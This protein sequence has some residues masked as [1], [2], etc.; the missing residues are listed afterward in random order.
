MFVPRMLSGLLIAL[1]VSAL[2]CSSAM[3]VAPTI[4][5]LSIANLSETE[6]V[7]D[8]L[9]RLTDSQG[10]PAD[11]ITLPRGVQ[12]LTILP[13]L[14]VVP[15]NEPIVGQVSVK[16]SIDLGKASSAT[17]IQLA[18][19]KEREIA[20]KLALLLESQTDVTVQFASGN[21]LETETGLI[22]GTGN[23]TAS[24]TA[25]AESNAPASVALR[26]S[27]DGSTIHIPR[28]QIVTISLAVSDE[29]RTIWICKSGATYLRFWQAIPSPWQLYYRLAV[30]TTE[31]RR[32][33]IVTQVVPFAI[34]NNPTTIPLDD[35]TVEVIPA[36]QN[37]G[38]QVSS[39]SMKPQAVA[40]LRLRERPEVQ[41]LI[42]QLP[43][44]F[45]ADRAAQ[46]SPVEVIE[47]SNNVPGQND[48]LPA[49]WDIYSSEPTG[50][51]FDITNSEILGT[52]EF[53][54]IPHTRWL[55][56]SLDWLPANQQPVS[57]NQHP[58][59]VFLKGNVI[60]DLTFKD[61]ELQLPVLPKSL[62]KGQLAF[63]TQVSMTVERT[64]IGPVKFHMVFPFDKNWPLLSGPKLVKTK[65]PKYS[66]RVI[67]QKGTTI[68][69]GKSA[70]D[71]LTS[72]QLKSL[73]A[74][75]AKTNPHLSVRLNKIADL[76]DR[77]ADL[78]NAMASEA[79]ELDSVTFE[80][81]F[82]TRPTPLPSSHNEQA[83]AQRRYTALRRQ[84]QNQGYELRKL[85]SLLLREQIR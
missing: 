57:I 61:F 65:L 29:S 3:A 4:K 48:L 22:I 81:D 46:S 37:Q 8:V 63:E 53:P 26:K 77:I 24:A 2:M 23:L 14:D 55:T 20:A 18:L 25:V 5:R 80:L 28:D 17:T 27:S 52:S 21:K 59:R 9:V 68:S 47:I 41:V 60:S 43:V 67:R 66:F 33:P 16:P 39:I 83:D 51:G 32:Q 10:K 75:V 62:T 19:L 45:V 58:S 44:Y 42:P 72:D 11:S 12:G 35:A 40:K 1:A 85:E 64:T 78:T 84:L 34:I 30:K 69:N 70:V 6:A 7:A 71:T 74:A 56:Q 36:G 49:T 38:F 82:L 76:R 13:T 79:N 31:A 50:S 73:A 54:A 15:E